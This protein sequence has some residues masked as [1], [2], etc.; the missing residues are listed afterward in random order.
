MIAF[1]IL[2][3][4]DKVIVGTVQFLAVT[5]FLMAG[6]HIDL[7][8]YYRLEMLALCLQ[9]TVLLVTVVLELLNA[10]HITVISHG[11]TPHT[12]TYRLVNQLLDIGLAVKQRVLRMHM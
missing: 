3:Q 7:T 4:Q 11:N 12:I 10:H 5:L 1:L 6:G 9:F 2:G 8:A